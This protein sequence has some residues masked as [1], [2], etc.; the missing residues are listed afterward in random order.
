MNDDGVERFGA[1][2]DALADVIGHADRVRPLNGTNQLPRVVDGIKLTD[3][4]AL[5]DA[6]TRA[7]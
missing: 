5:S 6:A 1:F 3:G 2:V 4:I 7:A